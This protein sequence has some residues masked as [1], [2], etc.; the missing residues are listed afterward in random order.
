MVS[1][2]TDLLLDVWVMLRPLYGV[3]TAAVDGIL[4]GLTIVRFK[5]DVVMGTVE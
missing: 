1:I 3:E 5:I 2:G 4:K